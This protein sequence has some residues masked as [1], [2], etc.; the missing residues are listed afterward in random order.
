MRVVLADDA[1]LLRSALVTLLA[2]HGCTVVGEA[3]TAHDAIRL[4]LAE[5]PELVLMDVR[6]P[7][8]RSN[9]GIVAAHRIRAEA[10]DV[11]ILLLSQ[12][13]ILDGLSE[14]LATGPG[15]GYLL[16]ETVT[17]ITGLLD[18]MRRLGEGGV[19][20]DPL[21]LRQLGPSAGPARIW[22]P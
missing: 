20:I 16:K 14:L 21:V 9:E 15:V 7:P 12:D 13:V 1:E 6:M 18:A 4:T 8:G 5:R 3:A 19:V 10:P 22:R 17:G 2:H 11:A